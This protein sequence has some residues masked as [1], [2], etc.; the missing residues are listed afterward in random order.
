MMKT[1]LEVQRH[2]AEIERWL[3]R[4]LKGWTI[5]DARPPVSSLLWAYRE[6]ME[7][8]RILSRVLI[9]AAAR[10]IELRDPPAAPAEAKA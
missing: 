7:Q 4:E 5:N 8:N 9:E 10:G 3:D 1:T 2:I 6:A